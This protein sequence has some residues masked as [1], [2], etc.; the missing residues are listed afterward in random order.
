MIY[1]YVIQKMVDNEDIKFDN[2]FIVLFVASNGV[3]L[4]EE[5]LISTLFH[6]HGRILISLEIKRNLLFISRQAF[7]KEATKTSNVYYELMF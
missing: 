5:G 6:P 7:K 3:S 1:F 2:S 4:L